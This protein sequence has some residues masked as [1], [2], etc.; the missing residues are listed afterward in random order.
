MGVLLMIVTVLGLVGAALVVAFALVTGKA[1]VARFVLAAAGV[2]AVTY[3]LLLV[4]ASVTSKERLLAV[5]EAKEYCGFYLD[6]HL[7]TMVTAVRT[8]KTIGDRTAKGTYYIAS[9]RVFS[10]ARNP[11]IKLHL[12]EPKARVIG[13]DGLYIERD[14]AAEAALPTADAALDRD[15]D[16]SEAITKEIVFDIP[17]SVTRPR[18]LITEGY[19]IDKTIE[20][21]LIGDEDSVFHAQTFF[22]LEVQPETTGVEIR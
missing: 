10:D 15:I 13:A 21:L 2:W 20:H 17:A 18:L 5:G 16:N 11:A 6:C 14:T 9:V 22:D 12:L 3:T 1:W 8:A 19:G 4:G 7:H